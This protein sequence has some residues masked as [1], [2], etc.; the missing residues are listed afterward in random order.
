MN[1]IE[2]NIKGIKCEGCVNRIKNVLSSIKGIDSF[3]ILVDGKTVGDVDFL[4]VYPKASLI[5]PPT[6][7]V[8]P[9]TICMLAYNC[10]KSVYGQ[11]VDDVLEQGIRKVKKIIKEKN[12]NL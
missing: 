1:K 12:R 6:G 11:E 3:D 5:T 4:D 7:A 2:L 10:A 8:G 9:M